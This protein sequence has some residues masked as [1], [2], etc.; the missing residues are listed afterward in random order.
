MK[1]NTNDIVLFG[2][3][4]K[5]KLKVSLLHLYLASIRVKRNYKGRILSV[6][7]VYSSQCH[8]LAPTIR[9]L[10]KN[11]MA[12]KSMSLTRI[13]TK[14]DSKWAKTQ[15]VQGR[16]EVEREIDKWKMITIKYL[17]LPLVYTLYESL[18]SWQEFL[19]RIYRYYSVFL[20]LED[21]K[22]LC[23]YSY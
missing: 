19:L 14:D 1:Q 2:V 8:T 10:V 7:G 4:L 5:Y 12:H 11:T 6:T 21:F 22:W 3:N 20:I 23:I 15:I 9:L 13:S 17:F 18:C 16:R